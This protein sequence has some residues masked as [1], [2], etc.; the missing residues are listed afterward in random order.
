MK[1]VLEE[2]S[3]DLLKI[4]DASYINAP[5][6]GYIQS[7]FQPPPPNL[8]QFVFGGERTLFGITQTDEITTYL[9][10]QYYEPKPDPILLP[11]MNE[12]DLYG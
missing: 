1:V 10:D 12:D 2:D 7:G 3:R 5:G 11:P 6:R 8:I 9:H 4:P